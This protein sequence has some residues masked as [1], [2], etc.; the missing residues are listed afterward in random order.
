MSLKAH[1]RLRPS[2]ASGWSAA[3]PL[4]SLL[5][6]LV[7]Y[8]MFAFREILLPGLY[9]DS[10][11]PDYQAAWLVRGNRDI[12]AWLFPD[13][14]IAGWHR[15]PLLNS[16]YGG[17]TTAYLGLLFFTVTGFSIE[18]VRI[19]HSVLGAGVLCALWWCLR[20]WRLPTLPVAAV[21]AALALD[22]TFVF[23]W[24]TQ[25]YLQLFPLIF[26][27]CGLG[28]LGRHH[29]TPGDGRTEY[30][31][32]FIAGALLGF[33]AYGYFVF[34]FHAVSAIALYAYAQGWRRDRLLLIGPPLVAGAAA[35][36]LPYVYAH[37][38]I[39]LQIGF[40]SYL[41]ELRNLQTA[42]GVIDQAQGVLGR[43]LAVAER[44]G[45]LVRGRSLSHGVFR[46]G[47]G[48][49]LSA[50]LTATYFGS[51]PLLFAAAW[52]R[53]RLAG[54]KG[55]IGV[56]RPW[57]LFATLLFGSVCA[58][59]VFGLA[60]GRP[61]GLQHYV[62]LLP[63]LY[64]LP[65]VGGA[66]LVAVRPQAGSSPWRTTLRLPMLAV[67]AALAISNLAASGSFLQRL[68]AT[69]GTGLYSDAINELVAA[70]ND[71]QPG[72][73]L[74]FPQWGYWMGVVTAVGPK[75]DVHEARSLEVMRARM[76]VDPLRSRRTFALVIVPEPLPMGRQ[77]AEARARAFADEVGLRIDGIS[78]CEGRNG[79]DEILL[80]R[81]S[82]A[83]P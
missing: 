40:S 71:L 17:N 52:F 8:A 7:L 75:F 70:V 3:L 15:L 45:Y 73:T 24:R 42:Y 14:V 27:A 69:G 82:R 53:L 25:H 64:L 22:P 72:T 5:L 23:A 9:M 32:L 51:G 65:F 39:V 50:V 66:A 13:N 49:D 31:T 20:Q 78:V 63:M 58:H 43:V 59:L 35:G 4:L 21:L 41:G 79:R 36:W 37:V 83:Q 38:S 29:G 74:L 18:S 81:M 26:L 34:A 48:W 61:L 80:V 60:I 1:R 76:R 47:T 30:R 56:G 54:A 77:M 11:N 62:I 2:P 55:G 68:K 28:L 57:F 33:S 12:P 10:V 44:L 46:N 16:L 6:P 67:A 19:F